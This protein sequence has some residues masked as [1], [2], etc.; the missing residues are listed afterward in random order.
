[1]TATVRTDEGVY[2]G[3]SVQEYACRKPLGIMGDTAQCDVKGDAVSINIGG[4][5]YLFLIFDTP[6]SHSIMSMPVSVLGAVTSDPLNATNST[7]PKRWALE[8]KQMPL[9]VKFD[10]LNDPGSIQPV[11]PTNLAAS[12]GEGVRTISVELETT[13]ERVQTGEIV[14]ILPWLSAD[15]NMLYYSKSATPFSKTLGTYSFTSGVKR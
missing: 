1:M 12:F 6:G 2:T 8:P 4:K 13:D 7:L 9:L 5:G 11:D 14:N 3:S 10:G 15:R